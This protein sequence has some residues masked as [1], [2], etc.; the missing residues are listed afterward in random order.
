MPGWG[1]R[2]YDYGRDGTSRYH[3]MLT[4]ALFA[5]PLA[6][7]ARIVYAN[8]A[9]GPEFGGD[10][11]RHFQMVRDLYAAHKPSVPDPAS[12]YPD[13]SEGTRFVYP[14]NY[15]ESGVRYAGVA[16]INT[17]G[18]IA[19]PRVELYRA[20]VAAANPS[21][22]T[23]KPS[24]GWG[25]PSGGTCAK[26]G[27]WLVR[28]YWPA[29]GELDDEVR[30]EDLTHGVRAAELAVSLHDAGL[31]SRGDEGRLRLPAPTLIYGAMIGEHT[32]AN[33]IDGTAGACADEA[34]TPYEWMSL[35]PYPHHA[36]H[37]TIE[38]YLKSAGR[39]EGTDEKYNIAVF[40]IRRKVSL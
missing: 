31:R 25:I 12:P 2:A 30:M 13:G 32:F 37:K 24:N 36:T 1:S 20:R 9:P 16:P 34:A 15:D 19:E 3:E 27:S 8:P 11:A 22:N 40:R 35:E 18:I 5:Y 23:A 21:R 39:A 29:A 6:A 33:Y 17:T 26:R 7:F 10:A 14:G 38:A 28:Y 4:N